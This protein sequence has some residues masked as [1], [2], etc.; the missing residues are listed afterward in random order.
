MK[1]KIEAIGIAIGLVLV[2]FGG[3]FTVGYQY[4]IREL[5]K[6]SEEKLKNEQPKADNKE[7]RWDVPIQVMPQ[8]KE[9]I[10]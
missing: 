5:E 10:V 2:L 3:G 6:I 1:E 9:L 7:R 8:Q 4:H